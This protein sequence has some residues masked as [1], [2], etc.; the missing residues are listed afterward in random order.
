MVG[1]GRHPIRKHRGGDTIARR[2]YDPAIRV[3]G[4]KRMHPWR[5]P[6]KSEEVCDKGQVNARAGLL[7]GRQLQLHELDRVGGRGWF[8]R[9]LHPSMLL[10]WRVL[11]Q[12]S[13][14]MG[15]IPLFLLLGAML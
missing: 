14:I 6:I 10:A 15:V 1:R 5:G 8:N 4:Y 12:P 9:K 7:R 11:S 3:P 2:A 13:R